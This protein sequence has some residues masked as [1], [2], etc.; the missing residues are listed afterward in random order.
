M[1]KKT[2]LPSLLFFIIISALC[3]PGIILSIVNPVMANSATIYV[4]DTYDTIQKAV[5]AAN[6][7]DTII[8]RPGIH[9]EN[10]LVNKTLTLIGQDRNATII[11]GDGSGNVIQVKISSKVSIINLTIQNSGTNPDNC[12]I[13]LSEVANTT[14]HNNIIKNNLIGVL[15]RRSNHTLL[16]DNIIMNNTSSGIS[17]ADASDLNYIIGNTLMNNTVGVRIQASFNT[18]YHNNF[19]HNK[20]LPVQFL[21][22]VSNKWDNGVEGNYWSDY[23]GLDTNGDGIG[24]TELPNWADYNPLIEPWSITRVFQVESDEDLITIQSNCTIASFNFNQSLRQISFRITGPSGKTF[25]CNVS[26]PKTLLHATSSKHWLIQLNNTNISAKSTIKENDYTSIYFT[27]NL[28]T[29]EVRIRAIMVTDFT[30]YVIGG[31]VAIAVIAI[32]IFVILR[33]KRTIKTE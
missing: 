5:N 2:L 30:P 25:F 18:F 29:Y 19:I 10:V 20:V 21:G 4:P 9:R 26:V 12:G 32:A 8:V 7:G 11:D 14:I 23:Y 13:M 33:K 6:P 3:V 24:D 31:G 15:L 22:G 17:L 1:K 28:S 16:M 27:Y